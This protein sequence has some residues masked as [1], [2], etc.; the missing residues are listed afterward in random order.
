MDRTP[1]RREFMLSGVGAAALGLAGCS[2]N[3]EGGATEY[4]DSPTPNDTA[5][6]TPSPTD[7]PT[8]T[9]TKTE[10]ETETATPEDQWEIDPLEH[11]KLVGAY[12]YPWY[13]DGYWDTYPIPETP[14]LGLYHSR[15][16]DVIN[17]HIKWSIEHG[18]NTWI[19]NWHTAPPREY[20][21]ENHFLEAELAEHIEFIIHPSTGRFTW[22]NGK[23]DFDKSENRET[24]IE[25]FQRFAELYFNQ[26]NYRR[27]DGKP[28]FYQYNA[29]WFEGDIA[30]AFREAK[31]AIDTDVY[32]IADI[33]AAAEHPI[34]V[35]REWLAEFDAVTTYNPY[36]KRIAA[37]GDFDDFLDFAEH[38]ITWWNLLADHYDLD[39]IPAV[40]P[41]ND[42][43]LFRDRPPLKRSPEG[44]RALCD[45]TID[46]LDSDVDAIFVTSFNEWPEHTVVEPG[47]Q[48]GDTYLNIVAD[49]LARST[50]GY[51]ETSSF[52]ALL[53]DFNRTVLPEGGSQRLAFRLFEVE[54]VSE[55][56]KMSYNVGIPQA[57][58]FIVE[59]MGF[60]EPN[61]VEVQRPP[62]PL[63]SWRWL[64]MSTER[65]LLYFDL[66][67]V[68]EITLVGKPIEDDII[69]EIS[70]N[71]DRIQ[72]LDFG[73]PQSEPEEYTINVG[74]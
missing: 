71:G 45:F 3:G 10:T 32:M 30:G 14:E 41:G 8:D 54:A 69:A 24:L 28:A 58:P 43:S 13:D 74:G 12:Y 70:I 19:V 18:I 59:G 4:S 26:P 57:E 52:E 37:D 68:E 51:L 49:Q 39:F 40:I 48:S 73:E 56:S 42:D 38:H 27:I 9:Q 17:Q 5:S 20:W 50:S 66:D 35:N 61:G 31:N 47:E 65:S 21:I 63:D 36:S 46:R 25:D 2:S 16:P 29:R 33:L 53:L 55:D 34:G 67:S 23:A 6:P 62:D 22:E 1:S 72:E 44:F 11:D 64:G 15:N 60:P 7:T